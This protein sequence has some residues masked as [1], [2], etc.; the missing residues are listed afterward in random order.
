MNLRK[1]A[2]KYGR[3]VVFIRHDF[4]EKWGFK[5]GLTR[6]INNLKFL[7]SAVFFVREVFALKRS[8]SRFS[9][10]PSMILT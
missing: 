8:I 5:Y 2:M 1:V 9:Q 6:A 7:A 4:A 3:F 10:T